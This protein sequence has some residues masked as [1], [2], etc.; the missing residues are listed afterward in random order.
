MRGVGVDQGDGDLVGAVVRG[1]VRALD[2][3]ADPHGDLL[4]AAGRPGLRGAHGGEHRAERVDGG[5]VLGGEG[6]AGR[7]A[8][9]AEHAT[10]HRAVSCSGLAVRVPSGVLSTRGRWT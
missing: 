3:R 8:A 5:L 9:A 4:G 7:G 1:G 6:G 10:D 2:E